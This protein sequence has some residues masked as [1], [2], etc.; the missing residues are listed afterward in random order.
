MLPEQQSD[1][2]PLDLTSEELVRA[3]SDAADLP[4]FVKD[5]EGRYRLCNRH[6]ARLWGRP[7]ADIIGRTDHDL[8]PPD[9][10][11]KLRDNDRRVIESG[12]T[13]R[14]EETVE[15]GGSE[16]LY[17]S[18]KVPLIDQ[19]GQVQGVCGIATDITEMRQSELLLRESEER[20]RV[21]ADSAPVLIWMSGCDNEGVF[22]NK[23]W[24]DFTGRNLEQEMGNSW[25][26]RVHPDD[27][28]AL[29]ECSHAFET[30]R[31]FQVRFRMRRFDGQYRW[32]LDTGLPRTSRGG[33]YAG[34]VGSCIDITE[35]IELEEA[36]R[37]HAERLSEMHRRKDEFLAMLGHELRNPLAP[38]RNAISL[39]KAKQNLLPKEL[40][41]SVAIADRQMAHVTRLVDD[42]LDVARI[43]QGRIDLKRTP[44][45]VATI[46]EA[47]VD[48][49]GPAISSANQELCVVQPPE[50]LLVEGDET[51]LVQVLANLL[52]NATKFTPAE[53]RVRLEVEAHSETVSIAVSDSGVGIEPD[54]RERLFDLFYR[55]H[56]GQNSGLGLGLAL[57]RRVLELHG[58]TI[59]CY[60]QGRG[61]GSTFRLN[62]PLLRR[63]TP[64]PAPVAPTV[65]HERELRILVVDDN[66]DAASSLAMLLEITGHKAELAHDGKSALEMLLQNDFDVALLDIGLPDQ[67]GYSVASAVR[68]HGGRQPLLVALT[69][70]G[71]AA[72]KQRSKEAGIDHHLIKPVDFEALSRIL[73]TI[74]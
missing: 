60:S 61:K 22:F 10:V 69:G 13:L 59:E 14:I 16:R 57:V 45:P 7:V 71:D 48:A 55:K 44:V 64:A 73:H 34:F 12:Q 41:G 8:L 5:L 4:I 6:L 9:L 31:A 15:F 40:Q 20:F 58:G 17:L 65:P 27:S 70:Y 36:L 49:L 21:L 11:R 26:D 33:A 24:L 37:S 42:L 74:R 63:R 39:L 19:N 1:S 43:T 35:Q 54:E 47:A 53:G 56:D 29:L 62:L 67:D 46:V 66:R 28:A 50:S 68:A 2:N 38:V 23:T 3:I 25:L 72:A 32:L 30:R 52:H 51:R 18:T